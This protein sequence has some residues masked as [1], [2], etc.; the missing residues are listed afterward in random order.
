MENDQR[1]EEGR[2]RAQLSE[3]AREVRLTDATAV[4]AVAHPLRMR[5]LSLLRRDGPATASALA[6]VVDEV[7]ASTSYHLRILARHGFIVEAPELARDG[8]ER[9]W[10]AAHDLTTWEP[11]EMLDDPDLAVAAQALEEGVV[12]H[13][14]QLLAAWRAERG[15]WAR[16]W[17][18]A[19]RMSDRLLWLTPGQL[20][21]LGAELDAVLDRWATAAD[22]ATE[23]AQPVYVI[24]H[25]FPEPRRMRDGRTEQ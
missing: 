15:T 12:R 6:A 3:Q 11:A 1:D 25:A 21:A 24:E 19:S 23:G 10:R 22:P 14:E 7:P 17:V 18:A 9:W 13:Y 5:L 20:A 4:R 2:S 16:D 8:R